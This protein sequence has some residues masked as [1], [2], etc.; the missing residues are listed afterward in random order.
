MTERL[1]PLATAALGAGILV[2]LVCAA[3]VANL[4]IARGAFRRRE[5]VTR[6]ALGA[7]GLDIGRLV[8]VEVGLL[9][10]LGVGGGLAVAT[11]VLTGTMQLIPD[12]YTTLGAPSVSAR[13][14]GF[15]CLTGGIVILAGLVPALGAWRVSPIAL[16]RQTATAEPHSVRFARFAMTAAQTA[17]S[18]VLLV[19]AMLMARSY[20]NLLTQ[21]PGYDGDVFAVGARS[22]TTPNGWRTTVDRTVERLRRLPDVTAAAA[23]KGPLVENIGGGMAGPALLVDGQRVRG[24]VKNVSH[25]FFQTAGA[26]LLEGRLL[27]SAD[28]NRSAVVSHSFA[29]ACC[30]G[31]SAVGRRLTWTVRNTER[32]VQIV[33][34]VK[35][36]IDGALD[37]APTPAAFIPFDRYDISGYLTTYV[38]RAGSPGPTLAA[39]IEREV[40][41]ENPA[42]TVSDGGLMRDRLM[43]SIRDRSFATLIVAFFG[44][45]AIGVSAAGLVGVVGFVVARR[46]REIA[47]RMAV[48]ARRSDVR[49]L[50]TREAALA[51]GA[52]AV[53]G[54]VAGGWL[55]RT[56]ESFLF[57]IR[58]A[59]PI[60][61]VLAAVALVAIVGGAAWVPARRAMRLSPVEALRVE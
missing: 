16:F 13:V 42:A 37:R 15:A 14:V 41:A 28:E 39:A 6:E 17:V 1:R 51:S 59:D 24:F 22:Q 11:T 40:S 10:V 35:D 45:A 33:G 23:M 30:E 60:S 58:P 57:G 50:V 32:S 8:L 49:R 54:F 55:S 43:R 53:V 4:L 52:G 12:Q 46:T 47:I 48:G 26:R 5:L 27:S 7:S 9:T 34:V 31:R 19:G 38:V 56:M 21:D 20:V 2:L 18:V 61:M 25:D 36:V 44:I 29:A 3:N